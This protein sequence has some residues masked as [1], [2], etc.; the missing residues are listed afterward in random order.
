MGSTFDPQFAYSAGEI[1]GLEARQRGFNVH[2]GGGINLMR[3]PRNGR[4]FE[5]ISEDPL[6]SGLMGG[7]MVRV[8]NR[9][10]SWRC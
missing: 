1:L 4:N 3:D 2:L 6:L 5:Y 9:K 10:T 8:L 7:A